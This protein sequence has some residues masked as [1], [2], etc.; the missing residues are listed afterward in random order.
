MEWLP[1]AD[2]PRH[3][4]G[5]GLAALRAA[6]G[7]CLRPDRAGRDGRVG[8]GGARSRLAAR[9]DRALW[10]EWRK[11]MT[12]DEQHLDGNAGGG[13]LGQIFAFEM[14]NAE[15]ICVHCDAVGLLGA[16]VVY[17]TAMGTTT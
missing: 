17:A 2:R 4:G 11:S 1:A 9:Q 13:V 7:V 12:I 6:A 10:S 14:T 16:A 3:A 8:A 5:G 15:V